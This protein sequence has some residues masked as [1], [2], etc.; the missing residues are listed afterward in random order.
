[1]CTHRVT[2]LKYKLCGH[3]FTALSVTLCVDPDA[4]NHE[5]TNASDN[6]EEL[7]GVCRNYA[8]VL[9]N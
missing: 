7:E 8:E 3:W 9:P 5:V 4:D 2:K 6:T 1:M